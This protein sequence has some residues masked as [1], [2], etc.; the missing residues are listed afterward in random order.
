[1]RDFSIQVEFAA[2]GGETAGR[3]MNIHRVALAFALGMALLASSEAGAQ[4]LHAGWMVRE[5][6][7]EH[8]ARVD[9]PTLAADWWLGRRASLHASWA[10]LSG[11][12]SVYSGD[13]CGGFVPPDCP[14]NIPVRDE[15]RMT[16]GTIGI[17]VAMMTRGRFTLELD[18]DAHGARMWE[19]T[20]AVS[21]ASE[22]WAEA[23]VLGV[24]TGLTAAIHPVRGLPVA[25]VAGAGA[26]AFGRL[27]QEMDSY[28]PFGGFQSTEAW[29]GL[30]VRQ[31]RGGERTS[32]TPR[33]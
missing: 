1:M 6:T 5:R 26:S 27:V 13:T 9:G 20:E 10:R 25:I 22:R 7:L 33:R 17:A 19:R 23:F 8:V 11:G 21:G 32:G 31:R 18:L 16:S 15:S 28:Q 4:G 12:S 3:P 2:R 29:I 24:G 14:R 30:A